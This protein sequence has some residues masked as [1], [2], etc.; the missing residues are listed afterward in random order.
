MTFSR[1]S[2]RSDSTQ[3]VFFTLSTR[4]IVLFCFLL[5]LLH[6][7]FQVQISLLFVFTDERNKKCG[8]YHAHVNRWPL[9]QKIKRKK[10]EEKE[11]KG[12]E[13]LIKLEAR[14]DE[15]KKV[16]VELFS[17]VLCESCSVGTQVGVS[18]TMLMEDKKT[19]LSKSLSTFCRSM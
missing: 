16:F 18:D 11:R 10:K 7:F 8:G 1:N 6:H 9:P 4:T 19:L 13:E 2:Q 15:D 17:L 14:V 12:E 5:L 3:P